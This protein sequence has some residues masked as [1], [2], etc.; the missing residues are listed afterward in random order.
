MQATE[1][2]IGFVHLPMRICGRKSIFAGA[3]IDKRLMT[4][5][6]QKLEVMMQSESWL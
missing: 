1:S 3:D 2:S 5:E 6:D 4:A